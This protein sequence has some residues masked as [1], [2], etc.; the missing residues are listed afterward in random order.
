MASL[1]HLAWGVVPP[2]EPQL[3]HFLQLDNPVGGVWRG[4]CT[5]VGVVPLWR[6][7]RGDAECWL[8]SN[9]DPDTDPISYLLA[10]GTCVPR[11]LSRGGGGPLAHMCLGAEGG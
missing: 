4:Y 2:H 9:G 11:G 7:V 5:K 3:L 8:Y 6:L 10:L 1:L